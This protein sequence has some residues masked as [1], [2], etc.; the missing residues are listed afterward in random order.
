MAKEKIL[1][2]DDE[3]DILNLVEYNLTSKGYNVVKAMDGP[4]GLKKAETKSPSLIILDIML[5]NMDG[6]EVLKELKKNNITENIPVIMLTAKGEEFDR[7][8]GLELGAD[9]YLT[10]PFSPR[11]LMLR[12]KRILERTTAGHNQDKAKKGNTDVLI[13][14]EITIDLAKHKAFINNKEIDLTKTEFDLLTYLLKNKGR[15]FSRDLLLTRVWGDDTFVTDRTVDTHVRRL[16]EKLG[17]YASYVE[18]VRG[19]GYRLKE[20]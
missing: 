19:A 16:R 11:E 20:D 1:I 18:T 5:P 10:K 4:E 15:V 12:V 17:D 3:E 13:F 9:D 2:V 14:R 7:V 8:L 6:T